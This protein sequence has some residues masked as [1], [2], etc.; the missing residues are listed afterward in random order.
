MPRVMHDVCW[1]DTDG[2]FLLILYGLEVIFSFVWLLFR[3][4][5]ATMAKELAS[6]HRGFEN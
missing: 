3:G 5:L 1:I 4:S 6:H 2:E